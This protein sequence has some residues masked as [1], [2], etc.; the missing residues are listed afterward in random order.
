[1]DWA[2]FRKGYSFA[3]SSK[4]IMACTCA[5]VS[6]AMT[7]SIYLPSSLPL[8]MLSYTWSGPMFLLCDN[9]LLMH[10]FMALS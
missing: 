1:M 2:E 3:V 5:A 7:A 6:S 10:G 8:Y 4:S 9:S